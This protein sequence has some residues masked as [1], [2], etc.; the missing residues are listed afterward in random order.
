MLRKWSTLIACWISFAI[1]ATVSAAITTDVNKSAGRSTPSTTISSPIFSTVEAN[2]LLLAFI[3]ADGPSVGQTTVTSMSGAGLTWELV[4][5]ANGQAGTS[6]IWR[7]F[8]AN[9]LTNV[10]VSATLSQSVASSITVMSFAGVDRSGTNG[11]GAIGAVSS[12][13]APTGAPGTSL[14]TTRDNS[15]V[16]GVGNDWDDPVA[17]IPSV[18]QSLVFQYF[19]S[20]GDTYWVQQQDNVI[21]SAGTRTDISDTAPTN[22]RFNLAVCEVL[23]A[24]TSTPTWSVSGS[25]TPSDAGSGATLSTGA[26]TTV[27]DASG[28][29]TIPGL[30][31]GSYTIS[32]SKAGFTF[33]PASLTVNVSGTNVTGANFVAT[34]VPAPDFAIT[35]APAT[36]TIAAGSSTNYTVTVDALN[37]FTGVVNLA[38]SGGLPAGATA[39]FSRTAITNSGTATLTVV[40]APTTPIATTT[41]AITAASGALSHTTSATLTIMKVTQATLPAISVSFVGSGTAMGATE[42]AGVVAKSNWNNAVGAGRT[43]PLALVDETGAATS[44]S[45]TWTSDNVWSLPITDAAGN[46]RLMKGYLDTINLRATTVTVAGLTAGVYDVYVYADGDNGNAARTGTYQ[47]SGLG[48]STTSINLTDPATTNFSSLFTQA[49]NSSGN[50]VKFSIN[51]TGFTLTATPGIASDNIRRAPINGLQIVPTTPAPVVSDFT[52]S[53]TPASQSVTPGK[54]A[55][56]TITVGALNGFSGV[57]NLAATGGLP[58]GAT[59]SFSPAT[60]TDAGTA[61]LT[62][63]TAPTTPSGTTTL[64]VTATSG[65]LTHSASATLLVAT[66]TY[67]L[68]GTITPASD[69]AFSNLSVGGTTAAT[70]TADGSGNFTVAALP[71]GS[72]IVTPTK[73]GF[74]FTPVSRSITISGGNVTGVNFTT[75]P[76]SI[77]VS[78]GSPANG[79]TVSNTFSI[80]ATASAGVVGVQFRVDDVDV[81]SEDTTA[82]FSYSVTAPAGTHTLTA[83]ARDQLGNT[84]TSAPV[85]VTV[86]SGYGT[87]LTVNG[88]QKYQTI[89]GLGVNINAHSWND[90]ELIPALDMLIDQM[91]TTAWRVAYDMVDWESTNDNSDPDVPNWT[92]YNA[93]YANAAFQNLWGTLHYLN[94][95]GITKNIALSFMGRVPTWMGGSTIKSNSEDEFV[96]TIATLLYYARN[97]EKI[98][99]D[100]VDPLNEPDWDGIE[101]PQVSATQ[102]T[103]ILHK[104][105]VKLDAMGLGD[106]RFL[107]PNTANVS[108][109]VSTYI[110]AMMSD[111]IVMSK[112]DHFGLHSYSSGTGGADSAIKGSSYPTTNFWMT[113][114]T[115]PSDMWT[116]L[117]QNAASFEVWEAYDGVFQHAILAGR[118]TEPGNDDTAG[119]ALIAYNS[120]TGTY[121]PRQNFYQVAQVTKFVPAG[122]VRIGASQTNGNLTVLAFYHAATG[123]VT[124]VGQNTSTSPVSLNGT[125]NSLPAVDGLQ[126]YQTDNG[127]KRLARGSDVVVSNGAFYAVIP[128]SSYFTLTTR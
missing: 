19:P 98:Q 47:V 26:I 6:E 55:S 96:E 2:E 114:F 84:A 80:S 67:S 79:A 36:Q 92:Y 56:Y 105:S 93:L 62:I 3:A 1:P 70:T 32:A 81:G 10:S 73:P 117:R 101:G 127:G 106:I 126:L 94:Q 51:G 72:Y 53:M 66:P 108:T 87:T 60:I 121:S 109:G 125:L 69:G 46:R 57:V 128:A 37:G 124:I 115:N 91:G 30:A 95:R 12:R 33:T 75:A 42:T 71:T 83:V 78:I 82:P 88:A 35:A 43:L 13:S 111:A 63:T 119:P 74:T 64:T 31:N 8:S 100:I 23:A 24:Q 39:S 41:L 34:A 59:A 120:S 22:D 77:S 18:G 27:A 29:Y 5:R 99:F 15:R 61:I 122:S 17:R 11:S 76:S 104:L 20:V 48:I 123:R 50:Y 52:V 21:P 97:T 14:V 54:T 103:R 44:A 45:I 68:S 86:S 38:V 107:G 118:G 16:F 112:V 4:V 40:T 58:A 113:E 102:Y 28:S 49:I 25:I 110:P 89:D 116:L 7:T 65:T 85:S 90:G 9:V